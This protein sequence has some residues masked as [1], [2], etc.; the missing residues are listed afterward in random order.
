MKPNPP[1]LASWPF[2]RIGLGT[3]T[4]PVNP[5]LTQ[6]EA[7]EVVRLVLSLP[8]PFFDTAPLYGSGRSETWLGAALQ[9][10]GRHSYLLATKAGYQLQPGGVRT[11]LSRD[12]ILR[13]VDV[14]L[15]RLGVSRL[16][17]VH[18]HDPDC[19]LQEALDVALPTLCD[20]RAQGV[21]GAV[22]AGMNQWQMLL[23]FARQADVDCFLLAGRYTLLEQTAL[24]LLDLCHAQG[25]AVFLGGVYNSGILATGSVPNARYNYAPAPPDIMA[26]AR[27]LEAAC[28]RHG[29]SLQAAALQFALGHPAVRSLIIGADSPA[30]FASALAG[31]EAAVPPSLWDELRQQGLIDYTPNSQ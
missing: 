3:G 6:A 13:S 7:A 11:D 21:I 18:L 25:L 19:C 5:A 14:S 8:N 12:S 27:T 20:L 9:D 2:P 31:I 22:G 29:V 23:E 26:R 24:P 28:A 1:R 17:I 10:A 30:Q 15:E 4:W 16:D